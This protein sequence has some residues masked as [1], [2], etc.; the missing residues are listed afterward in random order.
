MELCLGTVQFG[1]DYGIYNRA[2][3]PVEDSIRCLDYAVQNGISAL[4]TA[5]AYGMAEEIVGRFLAMKTVERDKLWI[6]TKFKPNLLDEYSP[7]KYQ[8]VILENLKQS[9]GRLNTDYVD[10]YYLHS[11]RYAFENEILDALKEVKKKRTCT[12]GRSLRI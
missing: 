6:S 2:M 8:D 11:A 9:L 12:E 7:D 4:D 10:A 3:P 1:M 5:T